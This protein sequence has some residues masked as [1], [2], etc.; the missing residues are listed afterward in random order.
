MAKKPTSKELNKKHLAR[1]ER[2]RIQTRWIMISAIVVIVL[3]VGILGY[4]LLDQ[5]YLLQ[6]KPV[7][8]VGDQKITL[9]EFEKEVRFTRYQM[10]Q[11]YKSSLQIYQMFASDA[12]LSSSFLSSLQ[13]AEQQ[14]S[15][16]NAVSLGKTVLDQTIENALVAQEAARRGI[17]VSDQE[18]DETFQ[19]A[20]G[21]YP[22]G[23][24][25]PT[26]SPTAAV[27]STLSPLQLTLVPPTATPLPTATATAVLET[28][29]PTVTP[30]PPDPNATSTPT[31]LPTATATPYTQEGFKTVVADYVSQLDPIDYNEAD[32]KAFIRTSLLRQKVFDAIT[33]DVAAEQDQVWA[34]HILVDDETTAQDIYKRLQ[35]GADFAELAK[36]YSTDTS[37][38][39]NGGDL[40]WFGSGKMV[41]DFE[42]AAF[43]MEVGQISEPVKSD[44]GWHIIQVLG[45]EVRPLS[46]SDFQN[47]RQQ[48]YDQW[49]EQAKTDANV[50]TYDSVWQ[51][52]VPVEPTIPADL[53]V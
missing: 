18:V 3:V 25:T 36:E 1:V 35:A 53:V 49:L 10:I 37:T 42:N 2:E 48:Q 40:G 34:R 45:H 50:Q 46:S 39:D 17:T 30:V 21:F 47:Q 16:S 51:E 38:K 32:L 13:Q 8:K 33:A 29:T 6:F 20:F 23:T 26:I 27:T 22:N 14:L 5:F 44:Y 7:A 52:N 28:A 24:L 43:S 41:A 11:Q 4:G 9:T 15:A 19:G 12:S 31:A